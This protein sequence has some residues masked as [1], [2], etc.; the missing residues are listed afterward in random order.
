MNQKLYLKKGNVE[1]MSEKCVCW[2]YGNQIWKGKAEFIEKKESI[3]RLDI[4]F[5]VA[6][7]AFRIVY[8]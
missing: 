6:I 3:A 2:G 5:T 4:I 7:S 8:C 1:V